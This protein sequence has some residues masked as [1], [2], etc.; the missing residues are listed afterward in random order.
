MYAAFNQH[1]L[2]ALTSDWVNIDRRRGTPFAPEDLI[3]GLPALWDLTPDLQAHIEAVHRLSDLGAVVT[4]TEHGTSQEGFYAEWRA[5]DILT[6]EGDRINRC[7]VF[8]E[9][10]LDAALATF[11]ELDGRPCLKTPPPEPGR[12]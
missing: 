11:D 1:E 7:E 4:H 3:A 12:A 5:I 9:A 8:D 6:V 2:P 10:D